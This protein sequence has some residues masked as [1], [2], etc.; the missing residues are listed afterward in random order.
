MEWWYN[1]SHDNLLK[2]VNGDENNPIRLTDQYILDFLRHIPAARDS[3]NRLVPSMLE[4]EQNR[5][6]GL[7]NSAQRMAVE[8]KV[9]EDAFQALQNKAGVRTAG[10]W[11]GTRRGGNR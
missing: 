9:V 8:D 2:G 4:E 1:N 10:R 11:G 3:F 6:V 7:A 5:L